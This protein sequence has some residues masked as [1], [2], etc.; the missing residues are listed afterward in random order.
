MRLA[1]SS[2]AAATAAAAA[3]RGARGGAYRAEDISYLVL[4][5]TNTKQGHPKPELPARP[6]RAQWVC[7]IAEHQQSRIAPDEGANHH[8]IIMQSSF[9]IHS[10]GIQ[11]AFSRPSAGPQQALSMQSAECRIA[12]AQQHALARGKRRLGRT[13]MRSAATVR[14]PSRVPSCLVRV[15]P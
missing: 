11:Q 3:T 13:T 10:A 9:I 4:L 7:E 14:S 12:P 2:A 15:G 5:D 8:A 6:R 1:S